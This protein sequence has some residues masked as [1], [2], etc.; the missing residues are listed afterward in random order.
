M[1]RFAQHDIEEI[2]G[3]ATLPVLLNEDNTKNFPE[4]VTELVD[5]ESSQ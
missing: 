4:S 3:D 5:L 1:L 2:A